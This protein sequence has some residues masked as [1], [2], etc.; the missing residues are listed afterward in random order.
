MK[1]LLSKR[2]EWSEAERV[3]WVARYRASG[4]SLRGFAQAHGLR[5]TQLHYWIYGK[6]AGPPP[7]QPLVKA[8]AVEIPWGELLPPPSWVAEISLAAGTTLRVNSAAAP[9]WVAEVVKN[10]GGVC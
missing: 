3:D 9:V 5:P 6:R 8:P 1:H 7:G 10:L 4:Q 2:K